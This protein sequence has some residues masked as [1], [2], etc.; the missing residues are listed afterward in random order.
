MHNPSRIAALR[1]RMRQRDLSVLYIRSLSNIA[2]ISGFEKVFDTEMA[3]ALILTQ[4]ECIIHSDS[5]YAEALHDRA[6]GTEIRIDASRT[7]HATILYDVI[8]SC[9]TTEADGT[10]AVGIE[11]S[12]TLSEFRALERTRAERGSISNAVLVELSGFVEALREVKDPSEIEAMKSAQRI[13]DAAFARICDYMAVGMSER[14]VQL[15]LDQYLFEEGAEG[16]A[17]DTIVAT[18]AHASS[19]HAI[20]GET[21]LEQG[22]AVVMDFGARY[23]GYCSDMTRTVFM[24]QPNDELIHAWTVLCETN[25]SCEALLHEGVSAASVHDR[26]EE[27]L[28]RAGYAGRMGHSLGHSV[29]LDIH[30]APNLSPS[31]A[32][33]VRAG[34]VVT[35]EPGIYVPGK[36]GMRLEDFGVITEDGYDV[37]TKSTHKMVI[38]RRQL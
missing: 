32:G 30:E 11:D 6:Q 12:L 10:C 34:N 31:N 38:I 15:Q 3:H 4:D 16:L 27:M 22:D 8:A 24:G 9:L 18:G 35:V 14:Q 36:F 29:G 13:T 25:E 5:R 33:P 23:A 17:F 28:S 19:P 21:L 7:G 26:A 2:W 37:F 20:P 1:E